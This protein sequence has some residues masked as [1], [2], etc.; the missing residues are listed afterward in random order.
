[1]PRPVTVQNFQAHVAKGSV[2]LHF[3]SNEL[4]IVGLAPARHTPL[5]AVD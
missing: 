1:L 3:C 2:R 5:L 4:R